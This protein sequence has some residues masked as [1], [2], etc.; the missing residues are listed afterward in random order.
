MTGGSAKAR[1]FGK[2][3]AAAFVL[4][5]CFST[6]QASAGGPWERLRSRLA[7]ETEVSAPR[8]EEK[9][10]A[11]WKRLRAL[12]LPFPERAEE[13]ALRD[14]KAADR[15]GG[16]MLRVLTPFS[17]LIAEAAGRFDIPPEIIA[18]VIMVESGGDPRARSKSSSAAGLMQ[19]LSATFGR[20]RR[21]LRARNIYI[22]DDPFDPRASI[23]AGSWYLARMYRRAAADA[24]VEAGRREDLAAWRLAAQYYYAG[25][26]NGR[27]PEEVIFVY[28]G[29]RRIRVDKKAYSGKVIRWARILK[30][31]A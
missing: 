7:G 25:P 2:C 3:W 5:A 9:N 18:A 28:A 16:H 14:S 10:A 8:G 6:A 4:L 15:V 22:A 24:P 26:R 19:T 21:A 11:P 13:A 20:A 1:R 23:M 27:R 12:Y 30:N 31:T 29:G 17:S